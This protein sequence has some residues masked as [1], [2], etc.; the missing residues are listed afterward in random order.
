MDK[1]EIFLNQRYKLVKKDDIVSYG[2]TLE[3]LKLS[4]LPEVDK[5][6]S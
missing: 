6:E 1:E 5:N 2:S 4:E 3:I